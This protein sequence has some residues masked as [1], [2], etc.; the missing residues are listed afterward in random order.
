MKTKEIGIT[1]RS[2]PKRKISLRTHLKKYKNTKKLSER[3]HGSAHYLNQSSEKNSDS[4]A[5]LVLI[6]R[7]AVTMGPG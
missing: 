3:M 4:Q 5:V 6:V 7:Q 2:S 1:L